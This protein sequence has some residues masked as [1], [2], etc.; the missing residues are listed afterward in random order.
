M[1]KNFRHEQ[2]LKLVRSRPL[3]SQAEL[4]AALHRAG[5]ETTQVTLSRDLK[6]LGLVKTPGGYAELAAAGAEREAG[7][8]ESELARIMGEFAR[9]VRPAQ[10]LVV[11]KTDPGAAPTVAAALDAANWP[12]VAGSLAG[13]DTVLVVCPSSR[14]RARVE[15]RLRT[16]LG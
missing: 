3:H 2:I 7:E 12:D 1:S 10:N 14:R 11:V 6:E 9:D 16:L 8:T 4:A 15:Q 5:V 13:D